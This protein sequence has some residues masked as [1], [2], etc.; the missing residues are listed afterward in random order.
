MGEVYRARDTRL[1]R[2]VAIKILPSQFSSDPVRKQRFEREAKTISHLNHP[3]ICVLHDIGSQDGMDYLV[4]EC[5]EGETLAKRLEKG[6][7]AL[8]QVL[9]LGAQIADALDKAHRSGVVHRDL[10]PGNIMLTPTGA[11]LLDFGLAKP[12]ALTSL[13]TL[14]A[15][16]Q[17][18]PVTAQGTIVGTFQYMSPEQ[19]EGKELDGRSDIFSLGAV[20]YEMLTGQRAFQG[21]SQLSVASAILE[22]E[23]API[24]SLKP[25]TPPALDHAIRRCLI[26]EPERR[27][28]SAADLAGEL[29]WNA[30][31]GSQIAA[32]APGLSQHKLRERFVWGSILTAVLA[33]TV[34]SLARDRA[35]PRVVRAYLPAPEGAT[36]DFVGDSSGPPVVSPDG[37]RIAF[38][39]RVNDISS[40]WVQS[41]DSGAARK[42]DGTERATDPFWSHDDAFIGFFADHK[43]KKIP[44]AG[45]A[46]TVLADAPN[47]RGGSWSQDNIILY[48]PDYRGALW[49]INAAGGA[50][51]PATKLDTSKHTTHRWPTFLPDGRH[52][53]YY[54]TN[55]IGGQSELNGI[56]FASLD[57]D[58]AKLALATDSAGQYAAGRLLFHSQIGLMAQRFDPRSGALFG[59]PVTVADELQ[60]DPSTWHSSFTASEDGVLVFE[61]GAASPGLELV[62]LDKSG[63]Q[64]G[65]VGERATYQGFRLSP[66]GKRLAIALGSLRPNIWVFDLVRGGRTQLTFDDASHYMLSW[67]P[68]GERIVFVTQSGPPGTYTSEIHVVAADGSGPSELLLR[69]DQ[70]VS[71]LFWPQWSPD[72]RYLVF[73]KASGPAGASVWAMPTYGK[74]A[75]VLV[76]QPQNSLANIAHISVSPDSR[77][78]AYS[79]TDSGRLEVYVTRFPSGGG[80]WQVSQN[81]GAFPVWRRDSGEVYFFSPTPPVLLQAAQVSAKGEEFQVESVRPLFPGPTVATGGQL[82]DITPDGKRFLV[83]LPPS[84]GSPP[85]TLIL[86]WTEELKKK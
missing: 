28:Q 44:S 85:L 4:M 52:F 61:R 36:F 48:E 60:Y 50:P 47:P 22:K 74:K 75:P 26:K 68:D 81:G 38:C 73:L 29:Q 71:G 25:L 20:L 14:T 78:L 5:V 80:R 37:T 7:L 79:S 23:P 17:E 82:F 58:G 70:P 15:T 18:S 35:E 24:S 31:S 77:W 6:P 41:L 62:W 40:V 1:E 43:L 76:A 46:T 57:S 55:H 49:R 45:G 67:S 63:K 10:K 54:A 16:K 66:D 69:P 8:E 72:G 53:L 84:V 42:L 11:K 9:K 13:A 32:S 12:A 2:T 59:E 34:W 83:S 39:A 30:E 27:W 65:T 56:Y 33:A 19:I 64:L 86:N 3:H 51:Q 21:R